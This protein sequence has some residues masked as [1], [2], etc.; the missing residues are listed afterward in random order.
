[1]MRA[2][3][4][5]FVFAYGVSKFL[6]ES[7]SFVSGHTWKGSKEAGDIDSYLPPGRV[8]FSKLSLAFTAFTV[9]DLVCYKATYKNLNLK[10]NHHH[11]RLYSR[12]TINAAVMSLLD[13]EYYNFLLVYKMVWTKSI[14]KYKQTEDT[15]LERK[16]M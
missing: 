15:K 1:M 10:P 16:K 5:T 2:Q 11:S 14:K 12:Q 13:S 3:T 9:V 8:L 4:S 6:E 7:Y